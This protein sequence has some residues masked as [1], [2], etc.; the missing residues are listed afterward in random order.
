MQSRIEG[1]YGYVGCD[2]HACILAQSLCARMARERESEGERERERE[3]EKEK[4]RERDRQTDRE[5]VCS[6]ERACVALETPLSM[7]VSLPVCTCR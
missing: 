2:E 1:R 6:E 7:H 5:N 4:E 3:R